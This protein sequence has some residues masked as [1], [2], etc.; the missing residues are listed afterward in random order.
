MSEYRDIPTKHDIDIGEYGDPRDGESWCSCG[1][2]SKNDAMGGFALNH[3]VKEN[4]P[5]FAALEE[6]VKAR[7]VAMHQIFWL[8]TAPHIEQICKEVYDRWGGAQSV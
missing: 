7:R 1:W 2:E 8:N 5:Y 4:Q 6:E 3:W